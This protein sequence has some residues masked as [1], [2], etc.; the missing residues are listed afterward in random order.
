MRLPALLADGNFVEALIVV[1]LVVITAI[2]RLVAGVR[3][4]GPPAGAP[5]VPRP[6]GAVQ[7]EI[8]EFLRRA[9]RRRAGQDPVD[10]VVVAQ[11][12]EPALNA[13]VVEE[14]PGEAVGDRVVLQVQQYMDTS[15][16]SRRSAQRDE[17]EAQADEQRDQRLQ[18][19]FGH[20]VGRLSQKPGETAAPPERADLSG[21][22]ELSAGLG[23]STAAI[24]GL[25]TLLSD[26]DSIRQAIILSEVLQ[27]REVE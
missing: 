20:D 13:E 26:P 17:G 8:D 19:V 10:A 15:D 27:R 1:S 3:R 18:Q 11:N 16:F 7:N 2:A 14:G 12:P 5:R 24:A 22:A 21:V 25:A 23:V 6:P 9:A 4:A